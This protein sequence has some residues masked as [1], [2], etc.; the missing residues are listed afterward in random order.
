M[1]FS[2]TRHA[3]SACITLLLS[4]LVLCAPTVE[5]RDDDVVR[6]PQTLDDSCMKNGPS[7]AV[8]PVFGW[9]DMPG[10]HWCTSGWQKSLTITGMKVYPG[11]DNIQGI[12]FYYS[13]GSKSGDGSG[14]PFG[15]T[16][17]VTQGKDGDA[18]EV[19]WAETDTISVSQP[20]YQKAI[21]FKKRVVQGARPFSWKNSPCLRSFF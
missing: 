4:Q 21:W 18:K 2:I 11:D 16:G 3:L 6:G 13:D 9:S 12:M 15:A 7:K 17:K 20:S 10:A 19:T 14:T 5:I 1:H 8:T